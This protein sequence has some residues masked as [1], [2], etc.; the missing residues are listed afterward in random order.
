MI[1]ELPRALFGRA[2]GLFAETWMDGAFIWGAFEGRL[3]G[4]VFVDDPERPTAAMLVQAFEYYVAGAP[5]ASELRRFIAA[6]PAEAEVFE[7]M[8]GYVATN[9][10]FAQALLD[11]HAGR[12]RVIARRGYRW[13]ADE[14]A[15][16]ALD[17]WRDMPA[18]LA[19]RPLDRTLAERVD[20]ELNQSIASFWDGYDRFLSGGFG[21]CALAGDALAAVA[22]AAGV[23]GG[24]ANIDVFTAEAFRR[25]GLAARACVAFVAHCRAHGMVA[26]WDCDSNNAASARLATALGFREGLPFSQLSTPGYGKLAQSHGR[27]TRE[28]TTAEGLIPYREM[29][30]A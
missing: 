9:T 4:R 28:R 27:W 24:E 14:A 6:A 13:G 20:R 19:I 8:Y 10:P 17:R 1:Y 25:Q 30:R 12:L 29:N 18:G 26:T 5:G 16:A 22:Y 15:G 11:D 7:K 23:G 3:A 2:R 21:F